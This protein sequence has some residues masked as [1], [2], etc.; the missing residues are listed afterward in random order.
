MTPL[1]PTDF[2]RFLNSDFEFVT[3]VIE[4]KLTRT[5]SIEREIETRY[6]RDYKI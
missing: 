1:S 3:L 6:L 5:L 4:I 2:V